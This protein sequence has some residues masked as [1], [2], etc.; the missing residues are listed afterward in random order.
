MST[1]LDEQ[2]KR[3]LCRTQTAT[4]N[5]FDASST[6]KRIRQQGIGMAVQK[7]DGASRRNPAVESHCANSIENEQNCFNDSISRS[8]G[9]EIER[10][11]TGFAKLGKKTP[12]FRSTRPPMPFSSTKVTKT[13]RARGYKLICVRLVTESTNPIAALLIAHV[14]HSRLHPC[15]CHF[16]HEQSVQSFVKAAS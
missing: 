9:I 10:A 11:T 12:K 7:R 6:L 2:K 16:G 13:N 3:R 4:M 14:H 15:R 8:Q 5:P 1:N